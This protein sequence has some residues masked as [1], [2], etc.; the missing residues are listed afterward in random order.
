VS[1][2]PEVVS[3]AHDAVSCLAHPEVEPA[4]RC[5]APARKAPPRALAV[6]S[7]AV[8]GGAA[9]LAFR[10]LKRRSR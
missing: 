7:L 2:I 10:H 1:D 6:I 8:A 4:A 5:V 3:A 9:Y